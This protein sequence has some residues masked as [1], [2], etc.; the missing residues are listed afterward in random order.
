VFDKLFFSFLGQLISFQI[1][2]IV[3][4]LNLEIYGM[5]FSDHKF[6]KAIKHTFRG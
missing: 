1:F 4:K 3:I 2:F 6:G 5:T